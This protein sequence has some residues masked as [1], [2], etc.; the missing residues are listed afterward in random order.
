MLTSE[1]TG[2]DFTDN[3]DGTCRCTDPTMTTTLFTATETAAT[4]VAPSENDPQENC[5]LLV[6][7]VCEKCFAGF[8]LNTTS[9]C[10]ALPNCEVFTEALGTQFKSC[11]VC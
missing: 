4:C 1:C 3:G 9:S 2:G 10:V 7:S 8:T 5:S 11:E 6:D